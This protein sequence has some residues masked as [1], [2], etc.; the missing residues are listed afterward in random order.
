MSTTACWALPILFL[1]HTS[2]ALA[3]QANKPAPWHVILITADDMNADS[4][5]WMGNKLK[6]TPSLDRF[7]GTC[8]RLI[9]HHVT[10][11]ICQPSRSAF[12]TGRVPHRN[13]A[14]GFHPIHND[15]PTLVELLRARGYF[16]A[17]INKFEHM[18]TAAKFPWDQK[19]GDS[20]KMPKMLADHVRQSIKAA[21]GAGKP[22]FLNVNITDPHRPFPGGEQAAKKKVINAAPVEPYA[23]QDVAVPSFLEDL[24]AVRQE[25]AQYYTAMRRLDQSFAEILA[26]LTEAGILDHAVV[27]FFSDHGMSFPF[28]KATVYRNGTWSPLLLRWPGMGAPTENRTDLVSSVDLL[29]S[30][31]DLLGVPHPAGL[32]GRSWLP[33]LRGARQPDR[34]HV[35]THVNTVNS[36]LSFP[37]RCVRTLK[38]SYIWQPW[39]DGTTKLRMEAMN[40]LTFKALAAAAATDARIHTRVQ[41]YHDGIV[42]GFYDLGRDADERHNLMAD[43]A[44]RETIARLQQLLLRHMERT[45][46]PQLENFRRALGGSGR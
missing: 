9:H 43:P 33:L 12:M 36:G 7:A 23:P 5:G 37:G 21:K 42:H 25:I 14:L 26:A 3:G 38:H 4:P 15:V 8:H 24:P 27:I 11:P 30:V 6:P 34:S 46:D 32:D 20:G 13:G 44:Q 10:A 16:A 17:V 1:A 28:S 2:P 19:L 18:T 22:L 31:L 39:P 45:E 41:Q 40:G 29:P 35:I